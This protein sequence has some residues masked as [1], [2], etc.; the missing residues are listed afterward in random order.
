MAVTQNYLHPPGS[1]K[2]L[3]GIIGLTAWSISEPD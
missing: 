1:S 3:R 2:L